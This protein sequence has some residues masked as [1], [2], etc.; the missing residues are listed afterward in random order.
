[1]SY[2]R[3][4]ALANVKEMKIQVFALYFIFNPAFSFSLFIHLDSGSF[5]FYLF[6]FAP[7]PSPFPTLTVLLF[8]HFQP[9][10]LSQSAS[11]LTSTAGSQIPWPSLNI[12]LGLCRTFSC[13]DVVP[14]SLLWFPL[15]NTVIDEEPS[16][17]AHLLSAMSDCDSS[18]LSWATLLWHLQCLPCL[19]P[20]LES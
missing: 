12:L 11:P 10:T 3:F 17:A 1:M 15:F 20:A 7:N 9:F 14:L 19:R 4:H 6:A 18:H 16:Q 13:D 5:C 2:L 8:K